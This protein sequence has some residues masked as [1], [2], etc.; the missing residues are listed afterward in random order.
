M[1]ES[2]LFIAQYIINKCTVEKKPISNL[3]LQKILYFI[4]L[5][6]LK[7]GDQAFEDDFQAWQFGPLIP[8]VYYR[9]CG[10]GSSL[11]RMTYNLNIDGIHFEVVDKIVESRRSEDP[12][13]MVTQTHEKGK[14][15]DIVYANGDGKYNIIPKELIR[16]NG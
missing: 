9:F 16:D 5:E 1:Y 2:A 11:I 12:W 7:Q 8:S 3:Q 15:W 13:S 14:A 4:Q 10:Y 6:F